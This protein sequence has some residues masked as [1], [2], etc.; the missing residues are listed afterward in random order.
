MGDA[1]I[2][3]T[4]L[5]AD[6]NGVNAVAEMLAALDGGNNPVSRESTEWVRPIL[7]DWLSETGR[8]LEGR[9]RALRAFLEEART[10]AE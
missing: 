3:A 8:R 1:W 2:E 5:A 4:T 7:V 9:A 10:R 6:L